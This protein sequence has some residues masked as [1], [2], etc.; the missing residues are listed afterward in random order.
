VAAAGDVV[1]DALAHAGLTE[2]V[3]AHRIITEWRDLVGERIAA[4]TWPDGLERGVLWVRVASSAWLHELTL[5]R[6]QVLAG[7]HAGLGEPRLVSEL[8][9]HLGARKAVDQDDVIALAQQ[10]RQRRRRPA[11]RPA[12]P[13]AEGAA[14][15]R[16][17][18]ETQAI[19]DPELRD[20]IR[21]VRVKH[22]R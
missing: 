19:G 22:D 2:V 5:L 12:G 11:A 8:R 3:R 6:E 10:A 21:T 17:E 4:R 18:R 14:R 16:I 9:L 13:P 7:I 15:D 20:L 1:A